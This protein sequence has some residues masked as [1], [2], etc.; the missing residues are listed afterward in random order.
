LTFSYPGTIFFRVS[1]HAGNIS[2]ADEIDTALRISSINQIR[3]E[4]M[5]AILRFDVVENHSHCLQIG[6]D[7]G[8]IA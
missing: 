2:V 6:M 1:L 5:S 3:Q 7:V 4:A 8:A